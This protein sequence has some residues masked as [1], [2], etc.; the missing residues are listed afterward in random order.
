[1]GWMEKEVAQ[2]VVEMDR[3]V[4]FDFSFADSAI[5]IRTEGYNG[6]VITVQISTGEVPVSNV[7]QHFLYFF[8]FCG[9][10]HLL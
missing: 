7:S 6:V 1:M 3:H 2:F 8:C 4:G 5:I 9:L 10:P